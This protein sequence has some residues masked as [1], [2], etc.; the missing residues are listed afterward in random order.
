LR[1]RCEHLRGIDVLTDDHRR[2]RGQAEAAAK[3]PRGGAGKSARKVSRLKL[4]SSV[5]CR[6]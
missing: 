3:T 2:S 4:Q 5:A 6:V 1:D